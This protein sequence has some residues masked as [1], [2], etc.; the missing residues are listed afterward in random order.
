MSGQENY[1]SGPDPNKISKGSG[2]FEIDDYNPVIWSTLVLNPNLTREESASEGNQDHPSDTAHNNWLELLVCQN[3]MVHTSDL[4][5]NHPMPELLPPGSAT[6]KYSVTE[7]ARLHP[8]AIVLTHPV[9]VL[10]GSPGHFFGEDRKWV[11]NDVSTK[12]ISNRSARAALGAAW[13][14]FGKG[15][16]NFPARKAFF[17][18]SAPYRT[19][20]AN[21]DRPQDIT[22]L[23][24]VTLW[25]Y[26]D[27]WER[28]KMSL[29][30]RTK[31]LNSWGYKCT[32]K[33]IQRV[34]E[35]VLG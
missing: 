16:I 14:G 5:E 30:Q 21:T 23:R 9:H 26:W 35:K 31:T 34:V 12:D 2:K 18:F 10:Y 33:A 20:G 15:A 17:K 13:K 7:K 1:F 19:L 28:K 25:I 11:V 3:R 6:P 22:M 8:V 29:E 24:D 32:T 4:R 27:Q